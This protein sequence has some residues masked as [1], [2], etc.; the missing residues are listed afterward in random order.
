M[1]GHY[2]IFDYQNFLRREC[3]FNY[4]IMR[5]VNLMCEINE[6]S[7]CSDSYLWTIDY[8]KFDVI[9]NQFKNLIVSK[10]RLLVDNLIKEKKLKEVPND[11]EVK[12]KYK[13]GN[14]GNIYEYLFFRLSFF[15]ER[16]DFK[17]I[18]P[19]QIDYI[20]V[21]ESLKKISKPIIT[22]NGRNLGPDKNIHRNKSLYKHIDSLIRMGAFVINLTDYCN[23]YNFD[24]SS[25]LEI[26]SIGMNYSETVSYFLNS[27]CL[28]SIGSCG[29]ISNHML[30]PTNLLILNDNESWI[31]KNKN[32]NYPKVSMLDAR[33]N[34]SNFKTINTD[35]GY[36][37]SRENNIDMDI[38]EI[39]MN[40]KKPEIDSFYNP[41]IIN[42]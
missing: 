30:T 18:T 35:Y 28:I 8:D 36:L 19:K 25:Y 12:N 6:S 41:N 16:G 20:K 42:L 33:R 3:E 21:K 22:I 37:D 40:F 27:N 24:N 34:Y 39:S 4:L 15:L 14:Y 23:G 38:L 10:D 31:D 29:G 2:S 11:D 1:C 7:E 13:Y 9:F 32:V 5:N 26:Q 17:F